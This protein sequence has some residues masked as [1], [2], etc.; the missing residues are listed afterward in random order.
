MILRR[1]AIYIVFAAILA[2]GMA[3]LLATLYMLNG[4]VELY[5]TEEQEDKVRMMAA[6]AVVSFA[7]VEALLWLLLKHLKSKG[8][9]IM[10]S[11]ERAKTSRR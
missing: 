9:L 8:N 6:I 4:S 10:P 11:T 5:P 3:F 2:V 1:A 7:F